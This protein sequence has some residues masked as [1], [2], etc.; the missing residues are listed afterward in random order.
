MNPNQRL[1]EKLYVKDEA[2]NTVELK[3]FLC[4]DGSTKTERRIAINSK[5]E[6]HGKFKETGVD[7]SD[8]IQ[9]DKDEVSKLIQE[10][11]IKI[12]TENAHKAYVSPT[13]PNILSQNP[14]KYSS[15]KK[16]PG[17]NY[18]DQAH[19]SSFHQR[20]DEQAHQEVPTQQKSVNEN[21]YPSQIAVK[22]SS[23]LRDRHEKPSPLSN[24][25]M[26][27]QLKSL[28]VSSEHSDKNNSI[29]NSANKSDKSPQKAK[30]T[31][32][33]SLA[34]SIKGKTVKVRYKEHR[35][36]TYPVGISGP[37]LTKEEKEWLLRR[38]IEKEGLTI[39]EI[40]A[41][42]GG[43]LI[44]VDNGSEYRLTADNDRHQRDSTDSSSHIYKN[45]RGSNLVK[46]IQNQIINEQDEEVV[47]QSSGY[48]SQRIVSTMVGKES[49]IE[50]FD[51]M[52]RP[53]ENSN[54]KDDEIWFRTKEQMVLD[55][56]DQ[57]RNIDMS[58][59]SR[60]R[61][62]KVSGLEKQ[63]ISINNVGP[64]DLDDYNS[65]PRS[66]NTKFNY[67]TN[68]HYNP[69][70]PANYDTGN[71]HQNNT[72]QREN[73]NGDNYD[74]S[75]IDALLKHNENL[76]SKIKIDMR[77]IGESFVSHT[78]MGSSRV[79]LKNNLSGV[80]RPVDFDSKEM[81][82]RSPIGIQEFESFKTKTA[83]VS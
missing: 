42:E 4:P 71:G 53:A 29:L 11:A 24:K 2:G 34:N 58:K 54:Q 7:L 74:P 12:A 56:N 68:Q 49:Q 32:P 31:V 57:Y 15:E 44:D 19:F 61:P 20:M 72:S 60:K 55:E 47:S 39:E 65:E 43:H 28:V 1:I 37:E 13:K 40:E 59:S 66:T 25:Q 41:I 33:P 52:H 35:G 77:N 18:E 22:Q 36:K 73:D 30:V 5:G 51:L 82:N 38:I 6:L 50:K 78:D 63:A 45:E 48:P 76:L 9:A 75:D 17:S 26:N 46:D 64:E 23:L 81:M 70:F 67:G 21:T 62:Q 27:E 8:V 69:G 10:N 3:T 14:Q 16:S 80:Y 79:G 83:E